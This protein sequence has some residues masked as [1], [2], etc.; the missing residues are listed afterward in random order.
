MFHVQGV[1]QAAAGWKP[2]AKS[3]ACNSIHS[4]PRCRQS[5]D[6]SAKTERVQTYQS[7]PRAS[8]AKV[9][10]SR[11]ANFGARR[12]SPTRSLGLLEIIATRNFRAHW[13]L[14]RFSTV[15]PINLGE[16]RPRLARK[17][18]R[19]GAPSV[20]RQ[21]LKATIALL[22]NGCRQRRRPISARISVPPAT[23]PPWRSPVMG[24]FHMKVTPQSRLL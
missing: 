13:S 17:C 10:C 22:A 15:G 11:P 20:R 23:T 9:F 2:R 18:W 16:I 7:A 6:V 19:Q 12:A 8:L 4:R 14:L 21:V 3:F 1:G 5:R 24:V